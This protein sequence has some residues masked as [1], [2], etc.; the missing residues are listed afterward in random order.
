MRLRG[1]GYGSGAA[2]VSA[3]RSRRAH[4]HPEQAGDIAGTTAYDVNGDKIGTVRQ[5]YLDDRTGEPAWASIKTGLFGT[6][7]S[8]APVHDAALTDGG[9][10]LGHDKDKVTGAP[11]I[12]D[13]GHLS[14]E[15][16]AGL[17]DYYE[18]AYVTGDA[19]SYHRGEVRSDTADP[20]SDGAMTRSEERLE[21]TGT[22]SS[23][24]G[25]ARLKYVE[26]EN[27]T[28]TVPVRKEK[29]ALETDEA[30]A[31]DHSEPVTD[32]EAAAFSDA[33]GNAPS[34]EAP[35]VILHEEVPVVHTEVKATER[36]RLGTEEVVEEQTISGEVR[37]ER[38]LAEGDGVDGRE[39]T[40]TAR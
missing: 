15:D 40:D 10:F 12:A 34:G 9:L 8:F 14:P 30:V 33:V 19:E 31:A 26:T 24:A 29:V 3:A 4:D 22:E 27:V 17:Y 18:V 23:V 16:E 36:V 6:H 37:K 5:V 28:V 13:D 39:T 7:E 2:D 1:A 38:I 21:V 35:E 32:A 11:Q 20:P 25:R